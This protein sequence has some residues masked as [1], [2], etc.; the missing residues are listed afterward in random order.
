MISAG[1]GDVGG[2]NG[3]AGDGEGQQR[4]LA[5]GARR[6]PA[7]AGGYPFIFVGSGLSRGSAR[8]Y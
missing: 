1:N 8:I 5:V 4:H 2:G 6:V 7:G 3:D